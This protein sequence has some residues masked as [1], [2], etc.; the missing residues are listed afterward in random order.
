MRKITRRSF[1]VLL[2]GA[3]TVLGT[4]WLRGRRAHRFARELPNVL[5]PG[6]HTQMIG[7]QYLRKVPEEADPD[8]LS[9]LILS[10]LPWDAAIETDLRVLVRELVRRDFAEARV[11]RLGQWLL[12][13]TEARL[14]ALTAL[15]NR[16]S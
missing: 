3:G 5:P 10:D 9:E 1:F 4:H 15:A 13:Q 16:P 2:A 12:S 7:R 11:V 6:A 14:C 8:R